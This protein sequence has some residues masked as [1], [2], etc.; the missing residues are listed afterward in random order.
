MRES[1]DMH[2]DDVHINQYV[3]FYMMCPVPSAPLSSREVGLVL[4]LALGLDDLE[5][6]IVRLRLGLG[7]EYIC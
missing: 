2:R 6:G 7:L 4:L 5:A 3:S 1:H